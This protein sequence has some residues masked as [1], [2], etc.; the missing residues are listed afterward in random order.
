M[1]RVPS[2]CSGHVPSVADMNRL[3]FRSLL[4]A[5]IAMLAAPV[6]TGCFLDAQQAARL[7]RAIDVIDPAVIVVDEA[8]SSG[9]AGLD[10][11]YRAR[12]QG[13]TADRS[14]VEEAFAIAASHLGWDSEQPYVD[15]A[16]LQI[17]AGGALAALTIRQSRAS[18][19]FEDDMRDLHADLAA[20]LPTSTVVNVN[21]ERV[22]QLDS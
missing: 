12:L 2:R 13:N 8:R 7:E 22:L 10:L 16:N 20:L 4:A 9:D 1:E 6:L 21:G 3:R 17:D 19:D 5:L 11:E 15:D 14:V 18:D